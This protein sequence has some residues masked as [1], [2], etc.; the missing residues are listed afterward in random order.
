MSTLEL[1]GAFVARDAAVTIGEADREL[2]RLH[3]ADIVIAWLAGAYTHEGKDLS[4]SAAN[5]R[6]GPMG[7]G[8]L[9]DA[10]LH[11]ALTRLS[12]I[13]DIHLAA[14]TTPGSVVVPV[15]LT[16]ARALGIAD[17]S[18]I[19]AAICAGYDVLV[20][21]GEEMGGASILYRGIW[22]TYF[23]APVGA[24]VGAARLLGLDEKRCAHAI[25]LA[26]VT[27]SPN[28]GQQV[29]KLGRWLLL[30]NAVR[31]GLAAAFAAR[32]GFTSDLALLDK[33]FHGIYG[34]KIDG[35]RL[36][37]SL[38]A[39]PAIREVGFKPWCAARQTMA[40]TQALKELLLEGLDPAAINEIRAY[41][42]P[43][44]LA[45]VNHGVVPGDRSSHITSLPY[46]L[47]LAALAPDM[48]YRLDY[49]PSPTPPEQQAMLARIT[50]EADESLM[51]HFPGSWP[52]RIV[53][54]TGQGTLERLVVQIPG[55]PA[56]SPGESGMRAKFLHILQPLV[57]EARA[58]G[59]GNLAL[60][61]LERNNA[62]P[63]LLAEIES[64]YPR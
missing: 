6:L 15:A 31:N 11:C 51:E 14:G 13:D 32:D 38:Q 39:Q 58:G 40:A 35:E 22:P 3:T 47:A 27:A 50:V 59:I 63:E 43:A 25:G 41:V 20:R 16:L 17:R 29:G 5:R 36:L 64:A 8:V 48:M 23:N 19:E 53:V 21:L 44:Y 12:E 37:A 4:A 52:G 24:A 46:Q 56:R 57:G 55:D 9:G 26:L 10:M 2:L 1:L 30:G 62:V 33:P 49:A 60:G 54:R 7:E 45:M 18:T 34:L 42:P 28:V 61:V